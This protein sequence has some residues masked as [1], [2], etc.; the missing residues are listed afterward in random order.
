VVLVGHMHRLID[1]VIEIDGHPT[2]ILSC[3]ATTRIGKSRGS[4]EP[5]RGEL[6]ITGGQIHYQRISE[7]AN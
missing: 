4:F 7:P 2:R 3:G 5:S 6:L 1:D